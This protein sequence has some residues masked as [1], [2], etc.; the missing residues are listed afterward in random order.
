MWEKIVLNLLSNA[1]KFTFEGG[2]AVRLRAGA[3]VAELAIEDTGVGIP[4]AELPRLF[5]RF[6]RIE[7]QRGRTHEGT[8]IGL[9]LVQELVRLH[10]GQ[11]EVRSAV[12]R[13]TTFTVTVP[14]G[15]AHLPADRIGAA[16]ALASTAA[17]VDAFVDEALRWLPDREAPSP[18]QLPPVAAGAVSETRKRI[19]L[20]DD[21][22]DM[23]DYVRRLLAGSFDVESVA[24]GRAALAAALSSPP[25][26][27]LSD[28]MMPGL[29]G[30]ELLQA[31]R[32]DPATRELPVI[33]LSAR[34]GEEARLE[35][36]EAGA[37][38][39][40]TKPFSARE[41]V[42]RVEA[43][44][45]LSQLRRET[46]QAV[47][48]RE[49][50]LRLLLH[51]LSHRVKNILAVIQSVATQTGARSLT[52]DGFLTSFRGR[53]QAL[54][55]AHEILTASGW[56]SAGLGTLA[57]A[58]LAPYL[59]G[60]RISLALADA[61]VSPSV[62]QTAALALHELATN[63]V[64]HGALSVAEGKVTIDGRMA[65][66]N[67][68]VV[69]WH[70]QG[71]PLTSAPTTTGFGMTLLTRAIRHQHKGDVEL[72]W[73]PEGLRCRITLP[74]AAGDGQLPS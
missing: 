34:A 28:V 48:A 38:D 56:Q 29:D 51:E 4:A 40:L 60:R 62:A 30:F 37:D 43:H 10:G 16:R 55:A 33:L 70:E 3:R 26:L 42:A 31:L 1:F 73:H 36:L 61:P 39:Y 23:R 32:A 71:G 35:G 74:V 12:D 47:L 45:R 2:I 9:A 17:S 5:E 67:K 72:E 53:L 18:A 44:L 8:G 46:A 64:K 59:D 11:I 21:N 49:E 50:H 63:A 57:R 13:G 58:T 14:L 20:A 54:A 7:G 19:L 27:V 65:D 66:G 24:D 22:A 69:L 52:V 15:T 6:H 25:D 41:L 68:L